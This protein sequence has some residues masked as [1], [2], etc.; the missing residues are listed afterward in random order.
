MRISLSL[1]FI[2]IIAYVYGCTDDVIDDV[3]IDC[4]DACDCIQCF[5]NLTSNDEMDDECQQEMDFILECI[6][7]EC[8]YGDSPSISKLIGAI[9]LVTAAITC[10]GTLLLCAGML[11]ILFIAN[12]LNRADNNYSSYIG[13]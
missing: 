3:I 7:D 5:S 1:L 4:I 13:G 9:V 6:F 10:G 8:P 2:I 12:R 11:V